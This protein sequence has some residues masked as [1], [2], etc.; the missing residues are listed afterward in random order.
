MIDASHPLWKHDRVARTD[1]R[2]RGLDEDEG[3]LRE[4]LFHLRR[5][6]LV[7]QAD[8]HDLR[9]HDW[10]QQAMAG[11]G[12]GLA[13]LMVAKDV[14]VDQPPPPVPLRGVS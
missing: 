12:K 10:R 6:V 7:V 8:T 5:M 4:R 1:D 9:R 3:L 2:G 14:S 11:R 13:V